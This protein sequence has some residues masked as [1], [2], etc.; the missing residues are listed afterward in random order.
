V[1]IF[2]IVLSHGLNHYIPRNI[3]LLMVW[4]NICEKNIVQ[5]LIRILLGRIEKLWVDLT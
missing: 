1:L 4:R 3:S 5:S 2:N